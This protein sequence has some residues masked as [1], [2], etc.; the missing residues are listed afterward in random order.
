[1]PRKPHNLCCPG[2]KDEIRKRRNVEKRKGGKE[3]K[4]EMR[5]GG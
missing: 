3:D 1:M 5:K 4:E 2:G